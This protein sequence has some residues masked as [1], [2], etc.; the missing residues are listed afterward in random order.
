[1][2]NGAVLFNQDINMWNINKVKNMVWM[3]YGA[4]S[5]NK[6]IINWDLDNVKYKNQFFITDN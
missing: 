6:L 5:F 4:Y 1:M 2:F 3:F